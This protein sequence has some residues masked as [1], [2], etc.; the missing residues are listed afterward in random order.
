MG[1]D[2]G[3]MRH[4]LNPLAGR[5]PVDNDSRNIHPAP[6]RLLVNPLPRVHGQPPVWSLA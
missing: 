4:S 6:A 3:N 2:G 1:G 5:A